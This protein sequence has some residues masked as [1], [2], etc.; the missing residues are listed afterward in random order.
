[1]FESIKNRV[2]GGY[3]YDKLRLYKRIRTVFSNDSLAEQLYHIWKYRYWHLFQSQDEEALLRNLYRN[4]FL[5]VANR[6]WS[7]PCKEDMDTFLWEYPDLIMPYLAENYDFTRICTLFDEGPYE[8]NEK[9]SVKEG[10]V[11]IDCGANLGLFCS[12][13]ADRAQRVYAFEPSGKLCRQYLEP[14][15]TIYSNITIVNQGVAAKSS[16][17]DFFFYPESS[18][19]SK[20]DAVDLSAEAQ[21]KDHGICEKQKIDCF[22]MDDFVEQYHLQRVDYIKADIEGAERELLQGAGQTLLKYAPKLSICTYH[23]PDDKE[24]LER[25]IKEANP[26]Y[27]V[28]HL[29]K[30]LYA[31]VEE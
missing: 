5:E 23:L 21:E 19:S 27:Q 2:P 29:Y 26:K 15:Q 10:D 3:I 9:V 20:M 25:L 12:A 31:Y 8:L 13:V 7:I 11:V 24:V 4:G 28:Q 22:S 18:G 16:E 30:K 17:R 14:L 1:M 6:K